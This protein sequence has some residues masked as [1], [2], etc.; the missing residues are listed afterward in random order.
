MI[1]FSSLKLLPGSAAE[2]VLPDGRS[3][4]AQASEGMVWLSSPPL[5]TLPGDDIQRL[6]RLKDMLAAHLHMGQTP[7]LRLAL[8]EPDHLALQSAW[9][10]EMPPEAFWS[11]TA[12][13]EAAWA[14]ALVGGE[15]PV[16][17]LKL[18]EGIESN[19]FEQLLAVVEH[20]AELQELVIVDAEERTLLVESP[21]ETWTVGVTCG[22]QP[23]QAT[24]LLPLRPLPPD[25]GAAL[26]MV[27]Q[28]L[29]MNAGPTLGPDILISIDDTDPELQT[30]LLVAR[31]DLQGLQAD[32]LKAMI[33]RMLK[34]GDE[35]L[36]VWDGGDPLAPAPSRL[37]M[38][39]PESHF[40]NIRG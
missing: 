26:L 1:D 3:W 35:I 37:D 13:A 8:L 10:S 22:P 36:Q 4:H 34:L 38:L 39:G 2:L 28:A 15:L 6:D 12:N 32:D 16:R 7:G 33:G 14:Q 23:Q 27:R 18:A 31:L 30:L 19:I 9:S 5:P 11:E 40:I 20:D 25:P 21:Q 17:D 24:L 29:T